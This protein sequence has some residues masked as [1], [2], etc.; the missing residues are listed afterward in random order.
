MP[1]LGVEHLGE[2]LSRR[3]DCGDRRKSRWE[4][5][6]EERALSQT[7]A[8]VRVPTEPQAG[9]A[10]RMSNGAGSLGNSRKEQVGER[11]TSPETAKN[12]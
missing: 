1:G 11:G 5:E 12:L 6:A 2:Q 9:R 8:R 3:H 10:C 4:R 7:Q